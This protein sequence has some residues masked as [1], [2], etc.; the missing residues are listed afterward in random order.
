MTQGLKAFRKIQIGKE[1][2]HGTA[3]AATAALVGTLTMRPTQS[4]VAPDGEDIG[5][6]T[7]SFRSYVA[8][9]AAE[10]KFDGDALFEQLLYFL[11]MGVKGGVT[12]SKQGETA[13]YLWTFTPSLVASGAQNSFTIEYG[14]NLQA[15]EAEYCM[16]PSLS[17]SGSPNEALKLS[18]EIFGRQVSDASFTGALSLPTVE[19]ALFNA[20]KLYIDDTWAA[21]GGNKMDATLLDFTL[22]I[23]TG[24]K[25]I[26][27]ADGNLYF[28]LHVEKPRGVELDMTLAFNT[29]V[30][31]ERAQWA[32]QGKR[33]F[34]L[35]TIGSL[36]EGAYYKKLTVDIWGRYADWDTLGEK[37]GA[38]V[39]AVKVASV[40][41]IVNNHELSVAIINAVSALP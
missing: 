23:D 3:V 5:A 37:D 33:A 2:E 16:V 36:I 39:V 7:K 18:A 11:M 8:G 25:P 24:L 21:L 20:T 28:S 6:L 29:D 14:D 10:L 31:T 9:K 40:G 1:S 41:D 13:A 34:R 4:V 19:P 12:G 22:K 35:E 15:F 30:N 38:D 26:V 27:T 32:A 17:L